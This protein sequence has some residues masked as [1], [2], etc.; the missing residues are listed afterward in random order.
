[1]NATFSKI[2]VLSYFG[3]YAADLEIIGE[4]DKAFNV[5]NTGYDTDENAG[6]TGWLPKSGL[7]ITE[8]RDSV[9]FMEC[10]PWFQGKMEH[11]QRRLLN[12]AGR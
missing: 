7:K 3:A 9:A 2:F 11:R 4:S 1:M 6:L 12:C 10:K 5:K 8:V